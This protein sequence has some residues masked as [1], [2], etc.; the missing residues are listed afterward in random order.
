M[1]RWLGARR[2]P[3]ATLPVVELGALA[4]AWWHDRLDPNWRPHTLEQNQAILEQIGL[5]GSFWALS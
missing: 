1:Q 3:G 2:R 5:T 4:H